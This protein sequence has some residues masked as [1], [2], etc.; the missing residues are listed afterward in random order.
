M[1]EDT[2]A[3]FSGAAAQQAAAVWA[4]GGV[5][6]VV[7]RCPAPQDAASASG[8][9]KW[10]RTYSRMKISKRRL[11]RLSRQAAASAQ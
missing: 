4:E 2:P 6:V 7:E 1:D 11:A 5:P 10:A 8:L 3:V 9:A